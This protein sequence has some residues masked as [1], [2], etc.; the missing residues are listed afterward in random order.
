MATG[1]EGNVLV[2]AHPILGASRIDLEGIDRLL[3]GGVL[4]ETPRRP[5]YAQWQ[6][7]PAAEPR[8]F[9]PKRP[10]KP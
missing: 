6:L 2:G 5:P 9:P 4:E 8:N 3:L 1:I 7:Q 10:P